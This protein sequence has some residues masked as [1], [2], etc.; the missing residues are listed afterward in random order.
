MRL[1]CG[2]PWENQST[3]AWWLLSE[4]F[5]GPPA[6]PPGTPGFKAHGQPQR[7][8]CRHSSTSRHYSPAP[9]PV[10]A[11]TAFLSLPLVP[12][13]LRVSTRTR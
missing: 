3:P 7:S 10:W 6:Q 11:H 5:A 2:S 1:V 9:H 4:D 13:K 12:R 8:A